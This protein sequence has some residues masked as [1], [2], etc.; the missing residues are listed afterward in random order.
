MPVGSGR[1]RSPCRRSLHE[2]APRVPLRRRSVLSL[3]TDRL[4]V[5]SPL[6]SW[7]CV[8]ASPF[9]FFSLRSPPHLE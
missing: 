8:L 4:R 2:R 6:E 1:H 7:M 5:P 3:R 9:G